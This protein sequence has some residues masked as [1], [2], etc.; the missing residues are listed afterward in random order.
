[1]HS[2]RT[3]ETV[4]STVRPTATAALLLHAFTTA[5]GPGEQRAA[6]WEVYFGRSDAHLGGAFVDE[7]AAHRSRV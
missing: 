7:E 1:M 6:G 3:A 4:R 5:F 2:A